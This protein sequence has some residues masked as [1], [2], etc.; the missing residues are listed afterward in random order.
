MN[1]FQE[2]LTW[3]DDIYKDHVNKEIYTQKNWKGK[4]GYILKEV[5]EMET[6]LQECHDD[7]EAISGK[8]ED[9]KE[10]L[11]VA[12]PGPSPPVPQTTTG[13]IGW[14]SADPKNNLEVFRKFETNEHRKGDIVSKLNWPREGL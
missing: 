14:R 1:V 6:K 2:A 9:W 13:Q 8:I 5:H 11:P 3:M 7:K 4:H 10:K 12:K